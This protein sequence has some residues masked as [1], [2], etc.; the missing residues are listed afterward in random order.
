MAPSPLVRARVAGLVGV[1]MLASGSFAGFVGS[2][3]VVRGDVAATSKNIVASEALFRLGF[4]GSLIMMIA[5]LF[6]ALLLYGL[7]RPVGKT[8]AMSMLG[9]VLVSVPIYMLN[10]VNQ[11]AALPW[12]R[13][14]CTSR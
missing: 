6:Y 12:R 2:K 1:V 8:A 4:V 14:S 11:F 5:F 3:L 13:I 10:Q 9:L 7:L